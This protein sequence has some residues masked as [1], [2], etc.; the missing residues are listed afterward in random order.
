[1][2]GEAERAAKAM[3]LSLEELFEKWLGVDYWAADKGED[4]VFLLAP[5]TTEMT[6]GTE[7]PFEPRGVCVFFKEGKCELHLRGGPDAKPFECREYLHG[8]SD[9]T[10]DERHHAVR[11]A[12]RTH[13]GQVVE[14]LGRKPVQP[15]PDMF[16]LMALHMPRR[17]SL[18][19]LF[20]GD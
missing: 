3:G 9:Q 7:Y 2:P 20:G 18:L 15:E 19:D 11:D 1:M 6:P 10:V 17:G 16:D 4:Q 8:E 14:L 13:K 5:A 12:W